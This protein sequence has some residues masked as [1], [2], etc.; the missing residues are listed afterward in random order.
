[1][2]NGEQYE[3]II[4]DQKTNGIILEDYFYEQSLLTGAVLVMRI[5][6]LSRK[7][8]GEKIFLSWFKVGSEKWILMKMTVRFWE[9]ITAKKI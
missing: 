1:M 6:K 5:G 8:A 7:R 2:K 4:N 9:E 3:K